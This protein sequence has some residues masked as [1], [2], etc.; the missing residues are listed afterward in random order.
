MPNVATV[1]ITI[2]SVNDPPVLT[3]VPSAATTDELALYSFDADASDGDLP[4]QTLTFSLV[5]APAGAAIDAAT[6]AFSWTPSEA[7]GPGDYAVHGPGQ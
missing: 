1:A 7:Q 5:G 2:T 6:G 4:A 3:G